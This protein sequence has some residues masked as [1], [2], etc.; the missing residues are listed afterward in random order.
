MLWILPS[1]LVSNPIAC[2][3]GYVHPLLHS[4]RFVRAFSLVQSE[5]TWRMKKA[6]DGGTVAGLMSDLI[7]RLISGRKPAFYC[8][9]TSPRKV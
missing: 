9:T 6:S 4:C 1:Y 2:A 3:L 7:S 5:Q 8:T